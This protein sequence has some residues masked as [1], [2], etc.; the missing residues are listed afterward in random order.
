MAKI[1]F[2]R[3]P[4]QTGLS[5]IGD[6]YPQTDLK[7]KGKK[8]GAIFPPHYSGSPEFSQEKW[9][10]RIMLLKDDPSKSKNPNCPWRWVVFNAK[11]DEEPQARK[12]VAKH[13]KEILAMKL[14]FMED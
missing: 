13:E 8:F 11:F 2:R 14:F 9:E 5:A 12:Y 7:F 10:I 4:K 6:P 1:T 3:G